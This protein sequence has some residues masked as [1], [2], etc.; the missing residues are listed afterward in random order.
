M[1]N[2]KFQ[3]LVIL[4]LGSYFSNA[5]TPNST[6][7]YDTFYSGPLMGLEGISPEDTVY[8]GNFID[9]NED[10]ELFVVKA[11]GRQQL[12]NYVSQSI[13][14]GYWD[15]IHE[16]NSASQS[17]IYFY[18]NMLVGDYNGDGLDEVLCFHNSGGW[19]TLFK[20]NGTKWAWSG[21]N[22]GDKSLAIS[23]AQTHIDEPGYS[24]EIQN[25]LI[26][27][28]FDNDGKDE[29]IGYIQP[30]LGLIK[31]IHPLREGAIMFDFEPVIYGNGVTRT[32]FKNNRSLNN[33]IVTKFSGNWYA[34]DLDGDGDDELLGWNQDVRVYNFDVSLN[35]MTEVFSNENDP[36]RLDGSWMRT[37]LYKHGLALDQVLLADVDYN[38]DHAEICY[39]ESYSYS[40]SYPVDAMFRKLETLEFDPNF[41][42]HAIGYHQDVTPI[43]VLFNEKAHFYS[44]RAVLGRPEFIL[45]VDGANSIYTPRVHS[46]NLKKSN[47]SNSVTRTSVFPTVITDLRSLNIESPISIEKVII[48]SISGSHILEKDASGRESLSIDVSTLPQGSYVATIV[49]TSGEKESN[50]FVKK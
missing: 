38:D 46:E 20:W 10:E 15:L 13:E 1:N 34:A 42:V 26:S 27:G 29:I 22:Y 36:D 43:S 11:D 3:L 47:L 16:T 32:F 25:H 14:H 18:R 35:N 40:G 19:M 28:D 23:Q 39:F 8:V 30:Y 49:L 5:I 9:D 41:G 45:R 24:S 44:V 50:K 4:L 21:S 17:H 7:W 48:N 37:P 31:P 12:Y 6:G 33:D 2:A